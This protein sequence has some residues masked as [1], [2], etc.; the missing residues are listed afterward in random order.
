MKVLLTIIFSLYR[1]NLKK[2]KGCVWGMMTR[3]IKTNEVPYKKQNGRMAVQLIS[4]FFLHH[5]NLKETK[6]GI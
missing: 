5:K 4:G 6:D 1:K 2:T 3:M